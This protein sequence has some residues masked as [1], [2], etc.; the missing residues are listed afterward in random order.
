MLR[1]KLYFALYTVV[2]FYKY[3]HV[4]SGRAN[5]LVT[6]SNMVVVEVVEDN[7]VV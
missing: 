1:C 3:S 4:R 7:V 5:G 2:Y 6:R